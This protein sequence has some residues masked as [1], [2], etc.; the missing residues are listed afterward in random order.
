MESSMNVVLF[1]VLFIYLQQITSDPVSNWCF[2][3]SILFL[4]QI[5]ARRDEKLEAATA[6]IA[7]KL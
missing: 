4:L 6:Y 7:R 2:E 5:D 1:M 3:L